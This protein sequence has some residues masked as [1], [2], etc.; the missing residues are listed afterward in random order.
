[1]GGVCCDR[2]EMR[3]SSIPVSGI[4][5]K[6]NPIWMVLSIGVIPCLI[7][8][9]ARKQATC[10]FSRFFGNLTHASGLR[11]DL[12]GF[13][14]GLLVALVNG[15]PAMGCQGTYLESP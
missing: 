2:Q 8:G 9:I 3:H 11:S 10:R 1:M 7:P 15:K 4:P 13:G 14:S 5:F 12:D 6:G